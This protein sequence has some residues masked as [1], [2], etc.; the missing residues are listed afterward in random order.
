MKCEK[1]CL[2][3]NSNANLKNY[4]LNWRVTGNLLGAETGQ[5]A[6]ITNWFSDQWYFVRLIC[7]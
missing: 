3:V 1:N 5:K 7:N 2:P 6:K 4:V